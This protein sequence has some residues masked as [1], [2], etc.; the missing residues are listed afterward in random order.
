[1][2]L[3]A[4]ILLAI[5]TFGLLSLLFTSC[6]A[7]RERMQKKYCTPDTAIV[8]IRDTILT[9]EVK[10]DTFFH[11]KVDTLTLTKDKLTIR[12]IKR[13]DTVYLEGECKGDTIYYTKTIKV[14][15]LAPA[16]KT[17]VKWY[18]WLLAGFGLALFLVAVLSKK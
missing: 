14:P 13:G 12:Y 15:Y 17:A 5:I 8:L 1:M 3:L 10:T 7:H 16:E 2:K 18:V 11:Y 9:K 4:R 6:Q